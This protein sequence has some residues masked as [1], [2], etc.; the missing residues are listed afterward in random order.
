MA[1]SNTYRIFLVDPGNDDQYE[2]QPKSWTLAEE[3]NK[4]STVTLN[5]SWE[6][7]EEIATAYGT[8]VLGMFANEL[9]EL[10]IERLNSAGTYTKIFW[11]LVSDFDANPGNEGAV[12]F[13]V[14]AISWFGVLSRR[15][16][17]FPVRTFTATDA[18]EIAWTL[19]DESQSSNTPYSELGITEG[20]IETSVNRDEIYRFDNI[21]DAI[22]ALSNNTLDDGFDFEIDNTKA[23][24]V[25]YPTKGSTL[26]NI[27]FDKSKVADWH[28]HKPL[29]ATLANR[30]YVRGEGTGD[31]V[32]Y[33]QRD[34]TNGN[35]ATW[36][37]LEEVLP[38]ISEVNDTTA[39]NNRGDRHLALHEAPQIE[40]SADHY[41]D[42][43][44]SYSW[45]DYATGDTI[46]V[47]YPNLALAEVS[48]RVIRKELIIQ[49]EKGVGLV[50]VKFDLLT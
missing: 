5:F 41:D 12:N 17:G 30:V 1:V 42:E 39:L 46:I 15:K 9:R 31:D 10:W 22:V 25:Y 27:V 16:A 48:K 23:F 13:V 28:Y 3:L 35:K 44:N 8:D 49:E 26:P 24:N 4:E 37:L 14:K 33:V 36:T 2:L 47:D 19:I 50:K 43:T 18:G 38:S 32:V 21:R 29:I 11:G 20:V 7:I 45:L 34:G 6:Q 40:F